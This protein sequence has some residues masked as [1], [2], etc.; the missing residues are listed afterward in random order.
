MPRRVV[1]VVSPGQWQLEE[2]DGSAAFVQNLQTRAITY[3][4]VHHDIADG[5][6]VFAI[7]EGAIGPTD[8]AHYDLFRIDQGLIVEHWNARRDVPETT[9]SGLPIF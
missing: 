8:V 2:E 5:N 1:R 4:Q 7:S 9:A 3:R 6:F